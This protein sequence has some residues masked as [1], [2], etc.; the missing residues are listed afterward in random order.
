MLKIIKINVEN[1]KYII[2]MSYLNVNIDN[3]YD[4]L[5]TGDLILFRSKRWIRYFTYYTHVGMIVNFNGKKYILDLNQKNFDIY[6]VKS[7]VKLYDMYNRINKFNGDIF[8][9]EI[10]KYVM[11][12]D[13]INTFF[14]N[15][16]NYFKIK[17]DSNV[18][19]NIIKL[20]LGFKVKNR[21]G[22]FCSEFIAYILQDLNII[23]KQYDISC[24]L[25][26]TF[27]KLKSVDDLHIY[28]NIF[29]LNV[30]N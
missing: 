17:F 28:V 14:R 27:L 20:K 9:L 29:K 8:I 15:M 10:N 22:M 25:P 7:G 5:R 26:K 24:I 3:I 21:N 16:N 23:D 18:Y 12:D 30:K 1:C 19:L 13:K 6:A 11:T 2:N 4:L